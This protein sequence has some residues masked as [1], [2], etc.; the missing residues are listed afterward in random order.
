M[1]LPWRSKIARWLRFACVGGIA[2][3]IHALILWGAVEQVRVDP[4]WAT[5][6]GFTLA[7]SVSYFGHFFFTFQSTQ[8]HRRALPGFFISAVAGATLNVA[9][10]FIAMDRLAVSYW[11]AFAWT[12]LMVPGVTYGISKWLAFGD[13]SDR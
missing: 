12:I 9:I 5:L 3:L 11:I 10:F 7:F 2:T 1:I 13:S 6:L 8:S 4:K